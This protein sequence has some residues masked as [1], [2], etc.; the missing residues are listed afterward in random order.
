[1]F[2]L[3]T[4]SKDIDEIVSLAKII[5]TEHYTPIIGI[6]QVEY[7]LDKF[8]AKNVINEQITNDNYRYYLIKNQNNNVGYIGVQLKDKELFLSKIYIQSTERGLGLG[9]LSMAFIKGVAEENNLSK[10]TL[11]VNKNNS[12]TIAAYYKFGF[13]KTGLVCADIGEGYVMD[14][15]QMELQLSE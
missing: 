8:H 13:V 6:E 7:M 11:T 12:N 5:W 1:M 9:K 4:S 14:D 15:L 2:Q 3:V 10:I